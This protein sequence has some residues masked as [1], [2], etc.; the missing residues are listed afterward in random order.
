MRAL[1]GAI[2]TAGA[3]IA[4]GLSAHAIGTRYAGERP[5]VDKDGKYVRDPDG[6]LVRNRL[7]D[8]DRPLVF[9]LIFATTVA[10]AGLGITIAGL[11]Y[12]H[13]RR[14]REHQWERERHAAGQRTA[15]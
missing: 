2:I 9:A 13:A 11:A 7:G 14:E 10:V 6:Y 8:M 1:V 12:H 15:V 5:E 3:L 4:V